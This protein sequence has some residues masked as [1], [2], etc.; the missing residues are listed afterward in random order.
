M[1]NFDVLVGVVVGIAV[2]DGPNGWK[3]N[4]NKKYLY[5]LQ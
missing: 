4:I 3:I 1:I 2:K 5:V